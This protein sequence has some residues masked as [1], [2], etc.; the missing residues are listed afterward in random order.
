MVPLSDCKGLNEWE[1][2]LLAEH[3]WGRPRKWFPEH[4]E[5]WDDKRLSYEHTHLKE[6]WDKVQPLSQQNK[7]ILNAILILEICNWNLEESILDLCKA[8]GKKQA[9]QLRIGHN[10]SIT[11]ERWRGVWAYYLT[12]QKWLPSSRP[13]TGYDTLLNVCDPK[14]EIQNHILELLGEGNELK[15]LYVKRFC[16][17][18]EYWL[19]GRYHEGSPQLKAYNAAVEMLDGEIAQLDSD[20]EI[21]EWMR[22]D[23]KG[24]WIE[25]CHH[26]AFRRFDIFISSIGS[27]KWR[28][29]IPYRGTDGIERAETLEKYLFP[30]VVWTTGSRTSDNPPDEAFFERIQKLLGEHDDVKVFLASLLVSLLRSQQIAARKRAENRLEL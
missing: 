15:Q 7:D 29:A 14:G 24:V 21:L 16:L 28:G 19:R 23:G 22:V 6:L 27:G 1:R 11:E 4:P 13:F 18:L 8:I 30:I 17:N 12:L 25:I 26:K 9:P 3:R 5:W 2:E 20:P 10:Y